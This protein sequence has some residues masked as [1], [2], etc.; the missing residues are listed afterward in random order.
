[1]PLPFLRRAAAAMCAAVVLSGVPGPAGAAA[2]DVKKTKPS[3]TMKSSPLVGFSPARIVVTAEV[4]GG[5]E[6]EL[7]CATEEW[8]WGDDTQSRNT[9]DCEPFEPG[10]S[11]IKR[12]FVLEHV[13][14]GSGEYRVEFRLKQKNK[15]VA[16]GATE[17]KVRPGIRDAN[18]NR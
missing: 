13:F 8:E 12:R 10:R 5:D 4:R 2:D 11:T 17:V 16:R 6:A 18:E 9:A 7:Y 14:Q 3:V 1:M 15:V